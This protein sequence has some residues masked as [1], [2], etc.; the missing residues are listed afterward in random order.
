MDVQTLAFWVRGVDLKR[1]GSRDVARIP[2]RLLGQAL[3]RRP[4]RPT[5]FPHLTT[6]AIAALGTGLL[7]RLLSGGT[8]Y[9][10][11]RRRRQ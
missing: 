6:I 7:I 11:G 1:Q 5:G 8:L 4:T 10:V 9:R 2:H 3:A